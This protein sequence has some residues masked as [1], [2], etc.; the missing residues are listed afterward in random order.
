MDMSSYAYRPR[1]L[2]SSCTSFRS[3]TMT[4]LP[5]SS[6]AATPIGRGN[7]RIARRGHLNSIL[8]VAL[9]RP[10]VKNAFS[11]D[12]YLDLVDVLQLA[13]V[14]DSISAL[15]LTGDGDFFSSGADLNGNFMP[16]E[17]GGSRDTLNLPAGK[18]MMALMGF[19]KLLGVAVQGPAVGIGVTLLFHFD[20]CFCTPQATFWAPFTRLALVPEFCSS[21][22]FVEAMGQAKANELL[23][24]SK[25]IDANTALQWNICSRVV[26]GCD[27]GGDPFHSNSLGSYMSREIDERLLKLPRGHQTAQIFV[28]MIRGQRRMRLQQVCREELLRLDRRF[29]DGE[30]LEAAMQLQIGSSKPTSKL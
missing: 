10:R 21:T 1:V 25:K 14:D 6:T 28:D 15:V 20:L 19:P 22:T 12:L 24:L 4:L 5:P 18:F 29:D 7:I 13:K 16:D 27:S 11:D 17:E 2:V 8:L 30:V 23:M 3:A 9:S 26:Q